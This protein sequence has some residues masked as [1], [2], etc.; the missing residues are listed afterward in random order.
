MEA[1]REEYFDIIWER[2]WKNIFSMVDY[3]FRSEYACIKINSYDAPLSSN[4]D[5]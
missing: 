5:H 1:T 3:D 4:D 2:V